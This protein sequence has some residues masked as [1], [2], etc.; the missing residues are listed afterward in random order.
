MTMN[1]DKKTELLFSKHHVVVHDVVIHDKR[2]VSIVVDPGHSLL[3]DRSW[4]AIFPSRLSYGFNP[5]NFNPNAREFINFFG[6]WSFDLSHEHPVDVS[7][8]QQHGKHDK[9][10]LAI[11]LFTFS[12][13]SVNE[14]ISFKASCDHQ[15]FSS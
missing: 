9:Y 5:D 13:S 6:P 8:D 4:Y 12:S 3:L 14:K 2:N 10:H 11:F 1:F 7:H 15:Y